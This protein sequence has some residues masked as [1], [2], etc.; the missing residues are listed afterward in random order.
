MSC[1][2]S[3][4]GF[5][6]PQ[7]A[8]EA[9][10]IEAAVEEADATEGGAVGTKTATRRRRAPARDDMSYAPAEPDAAQV[11]EGAAA[12][13]GAVLATLVRTAPVCAACA[14]TYTAPR[15]MHATLVRESRR[16]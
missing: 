3:G 8:R 9:E 6:K 12:A 14:S 4:K 11:S 10:G 2:S 1:Y 16:N 7:P 13:E 5:G 15:D